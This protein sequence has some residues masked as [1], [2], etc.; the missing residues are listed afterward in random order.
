MGLFGGLLGWDA[1]DPRLVDSARGMREAGIRAEIRVTEYRAPHPNTY[2]MKLDGEACAH[3]VV[4]VSTGGGMVEIVEVDG[5]PLS[6][7]G[8]RFETLVWLSGEE[9]DPEVTGPLTRALEGRPE[10]GEFHIH[11]GKTG[12]LVQISGGTPLPEDLVAEIS[13]LPRVSEVRSVS[14][15]LPVLTP[16]EIRVP[17]LT[18]LDLLSTAREEGLDL[19]ELAIR[20][21]SARGGISRDEVWDRMARIVEIL[22]TS[23]REGLEGTSYDDRILGSQAPKFQE[24][25]ESG[26]ILEAGVLDTVIAYVAA[27]ME[28]KSAMGV[29]V[30][31]PT[32]GACGALPGACLG[33]GDAGGMG[34]DAVVRAMLAAGMVGVLIAHRSTFAAEVCGCQAECGA[35][36]GMAAAALVTL[37]GG[38]TEAAL[39]A[40]SMAIQ[41]TLGMICDPVANRVEVPCLGRNVLAASNALACANL[42]LAGFDPVV[43]LDEV[44]ETMDAVGKS[45]PHELRCTALGGLSVTPTSKR[46]EA[47]FR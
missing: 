3:A 13:S 46:I 23:I 27:L 31:A 45:L 36:S 39:G 37:A 40:A 2:R 18:A 12:W 35:G 1:I 9:N 47:R 28:V 4:A 25:R 29:I 19:G 42:A 44:I 24:A 26:R 30:A 38:G 33:V 15:V 22:G 8:D 34:R 6:M 21:E 17:F 10:A 16:P 20:Y 41:N 14:P 5:T 11:P 7:K 43:P 32:A